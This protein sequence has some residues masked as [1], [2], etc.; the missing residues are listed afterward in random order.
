M[1]RYRIL[2]LLRSGEIAHGWALRKL[3]K[4]RSDV[5]ISP[6][7]FYREIPNLVAENLVRPVDN[8]ADADSRRTPYSITE[9][10]AALF[11][12]WLR[13]ASSIAPDQREDE[14]AQRSLFLFDVDQE[15]A[16]AILDSWEEEL[17][18]RSKLLGRRRD[19]LLSPRRS[20]GD[21]RSQVLARLLTRRIK[22]IGVSLEFVR[23]L[24]ESI[25]AARA[26]TGGPRPG[27]GPAG[28]GS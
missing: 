5:D 15:D 12:E 23:E 4:Q 17:W 10:G 9:E 22:E 1:L 16:H 11:D 24:R 25:D 20:P 27:L 7:N 21:V 3:Y 14:L 26:E 8:P 19:A 13:D 28:K 18:L 6:G 2:G